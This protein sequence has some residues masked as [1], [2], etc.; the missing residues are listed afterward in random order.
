[1]APSTG[2]RGILARQVEALFTPGRP[3]PGPGLVGAEIELLAVSSGEDR[4]PMPLERPAGG[5]PSTLGFLRSW[6]E[7]TGEVTEEPGD[8]APGFA[9]RRG[10]RIT[11]EPGGQVEYSTAPRASPSR[12]LED[13]RAVLGPLRTAAG[14]AGADLVA[15]GLNPW[16]RVTEVPLQVPVARYFAMDDYFPRF[17]PHGQRIMRLSAAMQVNLDLGEPGRAAGRWRAA[18]LLS[19]VLR[20]MF[21]NSPAELAG[22]PV[23]GGRGLTW[24]AADPGRTGV[25]SLLSAPDR[26]TPTEAYL[27]YALETGVMLVAD[28]DR[29]LVAGPPGLTFDRWLAGGHAPPPAGEDCRIHLSTLFP[30]V[31][32][33][34]WLE[35]RSMDV[36]ADRWWGVPLLLLPALLYS[37]E[38]T[39]RLLAELE[40]LAS[41][42]PELAR[43]APRV[44]L[45]D[46]ILGPLAERVLDLALESAAGFPDGYFDHAMRE[47]SE[48]FGQ[49]YVRR[50][51][52]QGD[53]EGAPRAVL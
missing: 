16:H 22:Q 7:R 51:R 31:R 45:A 35:V 12:V 3:S 49:R 9:V 13:L 43:R 17:G 40:P 23:P 38:A 1:M 47:A 39:E 18:N 44:G 28:R 19:P 32:P 6:A 41:D 29:G 25:T 37:E 4:R 46:P 48:E 21:A 15:L 26:S 53:E 20:A 34:G 52:T 10:G 8:G 42:L 33:R 14:R 2:P 24:D 50:R 5:G 30:D 11:F 27:S 36:P